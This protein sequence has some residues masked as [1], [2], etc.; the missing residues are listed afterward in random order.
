MFSRAG[1]RS[2]AIESATCAGTAFGRRS[3]VATSFNG[4]A[5]EDRSDLRQSF[6]RILTANAKVPVRLDQGCCLPGKPG[7]LDQTKDFRKH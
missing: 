1:A 5:S 7:I 6:C 3:N 2:G 4:V